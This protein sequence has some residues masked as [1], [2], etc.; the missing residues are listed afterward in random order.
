MRKIF[1]LFS[2]LLPILFSIQIT[3]ASPLNDKIII[4]QLQ[5]DET[6]QNYTAINIKYNDKESTVPYITLK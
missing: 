2:V 1:T 6:A 4:Q 5:Y 3:Y